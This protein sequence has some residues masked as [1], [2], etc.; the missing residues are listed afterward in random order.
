MDGNRPADKTKAP[1]SG[2]ITAL[3]H[4]VRGGNPDA[5]NDLMPLVYRELRKQAAR[6]L[7]GEGRHPTM[8]PTVLVHE[9]YLQLARNQGIQWAD[10]AHF[11]AVAARLM[12][13]V[14]VDHARARKAKKRSSDTPAIAGLEV[15]ADDRVLDVLI[16]DEALDRLAA[17]DARQSRVVELRV[18]AGMNVEESAS[19][20]GVSPRT[21][22]ADWQMA[23]A[24]LTRELRKQAPGPNPRGAQA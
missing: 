6:V 17:L 22:K 8:Q 20:L 15:A 10:R 16:L 13:R 4:E 24:W 14:L 9:A 18:F 19:V 5:L 11:F 3:L 21:V 23:R 2:A 7:R 12:R 1:P